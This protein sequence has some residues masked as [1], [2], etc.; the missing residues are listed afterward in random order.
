M[1]LLLKDFV[2]TGREVLQRLEGG[3]EELREGAARGGRRMQARAQVSGRDLAEGRGWEL[4][5]GARAER[6]RGGVA[7]G[8]GEGSG[9]GG[10]LE[11]EG[12]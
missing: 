4:G 12:G 5:E 3:R 2:D 9:D 6:E 10:G 11:R 8:R 1:S 7:A